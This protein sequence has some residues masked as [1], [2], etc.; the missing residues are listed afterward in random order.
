MYYVNLVIDKIFG[1]FY[2]S[3]RIQIQKCTNPIIM[4]S[5]VSLAQKIRKGELKSEK[6]VQAFINRIR[7]VNPILNAVVDDRFEEALEEARKTDKDIE[8]GQILD[9]DFQEK[10]FLGKYKIA[11]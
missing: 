10:P 3:R 11:S 1:Y 7:E 9:V 4:S 2:N 6:V 8:T 5:A